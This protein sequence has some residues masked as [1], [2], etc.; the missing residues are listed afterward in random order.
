[1]LEK[2]RQGKRFTKINCFFVITDELDYPEINQ[3]IPLFPEQNF[4]Y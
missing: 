4:L 2:A 3:V 1:M